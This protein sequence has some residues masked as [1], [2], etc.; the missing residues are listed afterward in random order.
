[1]AL[2][3]VSNNHSLEVADASVTMYRE[4]VRDASGV[5][6]DE[7]MVN[8]LQLQRS[9]QAAARFVN[10]VDEMLQAALAIV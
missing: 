9:Y 4:A 8:M 10:A 6:I 2:D 3:A 7:E 5:S 1:M